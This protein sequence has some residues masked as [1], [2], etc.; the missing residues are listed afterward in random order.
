V[1]PERELSGSNGVNATLLD[2]LGIDER[3]ARKDTAVSTYLNDALGSAVALVKSGGTTRYI[4]APFGAASAFGTSS[5][6]SY[7]FTGRGTWKS[8]NLQ[9]HSQVRYRSRL[10][11]ANSVW[12]VGRS[13]FPACLAFCIIVSFAWRPTVLLNTRRGRLALPSINDKSRHVPSPFPCFRV[14]VPCFRVDD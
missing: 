7:Q 8:V 6:N 9:Q 10:P 1:N 12:S 5:S 4:Y 2:G 14:D 3:F 11:P 13:A